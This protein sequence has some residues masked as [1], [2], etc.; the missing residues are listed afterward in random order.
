MLLSGKRNRNTRS[1]SI[2]STGNGQVDDQAAETSGDKHRR[3]DYFP[4]SRL[5]EYQWPLG[6]DGAEFYILQEQV[7]EFLDIRGIQRKY[8]GRR[9]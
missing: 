2:E 7:K 9:V 4:A 1:A 8:P 6:N 5:F 3:V